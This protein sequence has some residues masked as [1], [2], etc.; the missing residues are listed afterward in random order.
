M[1]RV[2][3]FEGFRKFSSLG[4]EKLLHQMVLKSLVWSWNG[5]WPKLKNP[6]SK[7]RQRKKGQ[8]W[9]MYRS[10]LKNEKPASIFVN[11]G[12]KTCFGGGAQGKSGR[13]AVFND[14]FAMHQWGCIIARWRYWSR[15]LACSVFN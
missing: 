8:S 12:L 1:P 11:K 10:Y 9:I 7:F 3:T 13:T 6:G 15:M 5:Q 4:D 14:H 2:V